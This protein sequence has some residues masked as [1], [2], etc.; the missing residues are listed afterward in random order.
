MPA[1]DVENKDEPHNR[2]LAG[3]D[4]FLKRQVGQTFTQNGTGGLVPEGQFGFDLAA[5]TDGITVPSADPGGSVAASPQP[6][7]YFM[8]I[9][10]LNGGSRDAQHIGWFEIKGVDLD[11][12]KLAA[13]D[14][15]SLNVIVPAGVELSDVMQMVTL[16][17][18]TGVHIEGFTAGRNA[19]KVYDL[20]LADV[21][22]TD[23]GVNNVAGSESLDYSL[24]L[25]YGKIAQV[26]NGIDSSGN[27]VK[28][29]E[30][31][32][33]VTNHTE[34]PPF[35]LALTPGTESLFASASRYFLKIDGVAGDLTLSNEPAPAQRAAQT[36]ARPRLRRDTRM[37]GRD[38]FMAF[39][40]ARRPA[41]A[42]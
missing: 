41:S 37:C 18:V 15:A 12:Q 4:V 42:P 1:H 36:A 21:T 32:Y 14:F 40:C 24:S 35:S 13:G 17:G 20:S 29:G 16:G 8:L 23:V 27:P 31:G 11:I 39:Y 7:D 26:T 34:I 38:R 10:G 33:D 9:D 25:D 2:V 6:M 28:N 19:T 5:N 30:F 22:A 3:Q